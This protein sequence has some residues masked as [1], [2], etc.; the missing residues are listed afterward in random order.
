ML[1]VSYP[2][3]VSGYVSVIFSISRL[4]ASVVNGHVPRH[5]NASLAPPSFTSTHKTLSF[6]L[7]WSGLLNIEY[8]NE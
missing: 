7:S 2:D 4:R 3:P 8:H 6:E 1:I 5:Q